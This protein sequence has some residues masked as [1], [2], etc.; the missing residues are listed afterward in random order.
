MNKN[1][2]VAFLGAI[3]FLLLL[4]IYTLNSRTRS[5][6]SSTSTISTSTSSTTTTKPTTTPTAASILFLDDEDQS[7]ITKDTLRNLRHSDKTTTSLLSTTQTNIQPCNNPTH[8]NLHTTLSHQLNQKFI[9]SS[10]KKFCSSTSVQ[11]ECSWAS[12]RL[13]SSSRVDGS[14][15]SAVCCCEMMIESTIR[16]DVLSAFREKSRTERRSSRDDGSSGDGSSGDGSSGDGSS[17]GDGVVMIGSD[18]CGTVDHV[19]RVFASEGRALI[20]KKLEESIQL[21]NGCGCDWVEFMH[22]DARLNDGSKCWYSCCSMLHKQRVLLRTESI[23]LTPQQTKEDLRKISFPL[24]DRLPPWKTKSTGGHDVDVVREQFVFM[25]VDQLL[26]N[27]FGS[28][29]T[30]M[31]LK[32]T[33]CRHGLLPVL[34]LKTTVLKCISCLL[35]WY[36]ILSKDGR[37]SHDVWSKQDTSASGSSGSSGSFGV[38][39]YESLPSA[40]S[41]HA[42]GGYGGTGERREIDDEPVLDV[43]VP[44]GCDI[45]KFISFMER[46]PV[47]VP[48]DMDARLLVTNFQECPSSTPP[49]MLDVSEIIR[50]YGSNKFK[51]YRVLNV[52]G[53][54]QRAHGCNV[55]HDHA[56]DNSILTVLDVDMRVDAKYF[57]RAMTFAS[58]G[59]SVYFPIVWSQYSPAS[60]RLVARCT[61]S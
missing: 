3:I 44:W 57:R 16:N 42:H 2:L 48:L 5:A 10:Q 31:P 51:H 59:S 26:P 61:C 43:G 58:H 18:G 33:L 49:H 32:Q 1:I 7:S 46:F 15:C 22:C 56:R 52:D 45:K 35:S 9:L 28:T 55:L 13:C 12:E 34:C 38:A 17:G 29:H 54:F 39:L 6:S 23:L 21:A 50:K 20:T 60:I 37:Y 40:F 14:T 30:R 27:K 25:N 4:N 36:V 24:T 19:K 47:D 41:S 11:C 8:V 53:V